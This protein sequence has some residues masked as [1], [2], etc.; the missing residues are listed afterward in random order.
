MYAYVLNIRSSYLPTYLPTYRGSGYYRYYVALADYVENTFTTCTD[1]YL[2]RNG[3][4]T[5]RQPENLEPDNEKK[6][7]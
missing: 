5:T 6:R 1:Y 7:T 3:R 4:L 2:A